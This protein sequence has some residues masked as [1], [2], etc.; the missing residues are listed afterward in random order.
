[1]IPALQSHAARSFVGTIRPALPMG[2]TSMRDMVTLSGPAL[3]DAVK[4]AAIYGTVA[5]AP[6]MLGAAFGWG[7]VALGMGGSRR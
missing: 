2:A 5:G 7:G 6:S 4:G 3:G 1:M